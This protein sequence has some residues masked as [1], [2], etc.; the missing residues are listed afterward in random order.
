M[1]F[2]LRGN[3]FDVWWRVP[4]VAR[5]VFLARG[6]TAATVPDVVP[7]AFSSLVVFAKLPIRVVLPTL[8]VV[9][10]PMGEQSL[11]EPDA[12]SEREKESEGRVTIADEHELHAEDLLGA[13]VLEFDE[14]ERF[15]AALVDDALEVRAHAAH[16]R[17]RVVADI[18]ELESLHTTE[19]EPDRRSRTPRVVNFGL[20]RQ[21]WRTCSK[22][23][24]TEECC[25]ACSRPGATFEAEA[26]W[27]WPAGSRRASC[28]TGP[29]PPG[30]AARRSP[31]VSW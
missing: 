18:Q 13:L 17:E 16:Q 4:S 28:G 22:R 15:V 23:A 11:P 24:F 20:L 27:R 30:W 26:S 29:A 21:R 12:Q 19:R 5:F 6:W 9:V 1:G 8:P 10:R 14:L 3:V 31:R 25:R 2:V 7:R